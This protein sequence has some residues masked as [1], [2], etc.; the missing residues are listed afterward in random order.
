MTKSKKKLKSK[1]CPIVYIGEAKRG[2][3]NEHKFCLR[4][5]RKLRSIEAKQLGY[6]A[7]CY[8]KIKNSGKGRLF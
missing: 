1:D 6:G 4:C 7:V 3:A 2:M 5:G 8:S